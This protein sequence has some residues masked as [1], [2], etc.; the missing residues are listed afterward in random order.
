MKIV[1]TEYMPPT[2]IGKQ[3][4]TWFKEH[5]KPDMK[6][7][8]IARRNDEALNLFPPTEEERRLKSESLKDIPEFVL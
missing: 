2:E 4:H 1:K 8:E 5:V 7:E 6:F 3:R